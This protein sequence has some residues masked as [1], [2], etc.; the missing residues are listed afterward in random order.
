[1]AEVGVETQ[2]FWPQSGLF[3]HHS[4]LLGP[5]SPS[6]FL[7]LLPFPFL[8]GELELAF[9]YSR[10]T[11]SGKPSL[12]S[13]GSP[14]IHTPV[15]NLH[16]HL[17]GT[18]GAKHSATLAMYLAFLI[19]QPS[20]A[21]IGVSHSS[22]RKLKSSFPSFHGQQRF[23]PCPC[24]PRVTVPAFPYLGC[25]SPNILTLHSQELMTA[26]PCRPVSLLLVAGTPLIH[27]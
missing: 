23:E 5:T 16:H 11:S 9:D 26:R 24:V 12:S 21:Q 4:L 27:Y 17:S 7:L 19:P 15:N 20:K 13:P 6:T 25:V 18:Q 14:Y 2:A 10:T 22:M 1:M 3:L 8:L